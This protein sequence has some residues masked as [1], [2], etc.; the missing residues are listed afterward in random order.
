MA[1]G[2]M[3]RYMT[4]HT[5]RRIA[6]LVFVANAATPIRVR[7]PDNP[8]G[9]PPESADVFR[10]QVLLGDYPKWIEDN[11]EPFFVPATSRQMQEWV[12]GMMLRT[13]MKALVECNRSMMSADFRAELPN[14]AVPTLLIHDDKDVSAPLDA[15]G[16]PTA[17][18]IPNARLKV[19]EDAPHELFITHM[20]R[21]TKDILRF[22]KG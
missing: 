22:T 7:T 9:I 3:V 4:R 10:Q 2:E 21:M 17:K 8:A 14:I 6:R 5:S 19:Y 13:S 18:L 11:R 20:D 16:L 15:T 1:G 12:R